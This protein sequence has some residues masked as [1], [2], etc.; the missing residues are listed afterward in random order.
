MKTLGELKAI[1]TEIE[2]L[3]ETQYFGLT[4]DQVIRLRDLNWQ[5]RKLIKQL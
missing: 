2:A 3:E 1:L 5:L 4:N